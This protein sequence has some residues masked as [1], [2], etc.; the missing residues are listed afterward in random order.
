[1]SGGT[2]HPLPQSDEARR[3]EVPESLERAKGDGEE[4]KQAVQPDQEAVEPDGTPYPA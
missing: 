4:G 2:G 1:M 3:G